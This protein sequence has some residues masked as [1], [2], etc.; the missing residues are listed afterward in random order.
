MKIAS[1]SYSDVNGGAARAAWRIHQALRKSGIDS[2]MYVNV[3]SLG[4]SSV[5]GPPNQFYKA[6]GLLRFHAGTLISKTFLKTEN[7][8]LHSPAL[9]PSSWPSRLNNENVDLVHL[10]WVNGEMLSVNNIKHI[11]KP[12]LWTLHDMWP[13]C[14]AEHYTEDFRWR[15]GY[16]VQNRPTYES[17]LDLNRWVW[18]RKLKAW[19]K[20]MHIVAPSRWLAE[21]AQQSLLM[22]DWPISVI[23]NALDVEHWQPVDK[24]L[25]RRLMNLPTDCPLLAFGAMGGGQ[26]PRKGLDLLLEALE[27]LRGVLPG[28]ELLVFGQRAPRQTPDLG[29]PIHYTGHLHDDVSLRILY[30]AADAM[31]VPSRQEAF[32]QTASEAHACGTPVIA[33]NVC[34]LPD[35][36]THKKNGWLAKPFDTE[37][38]AQGIRWVLSDAIRHAELSYQSRQNAITRFSYPVV[39][40]QY[41]NLYKNI[42]NP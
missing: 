4:D 28:L 1:V 18:N 9:L 3:A 23:P 14:G 29:F 37:D 33:F 20:P 31:V 41:I 22:R 13:F 15:D 6:M 26:D 19:K 11:S 25:A 30:S 21:C 8:I 36:I 40:N 16:N 10:H 34:G 27:H 32:G 42:L 2:N 5:L 17:K 38:L 24:Y 39:A 7:L 12:I 35:I